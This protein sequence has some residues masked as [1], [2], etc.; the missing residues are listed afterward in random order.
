MEQRELDVALDKLLL[1]PNNYRFQADPRFQQVRES[2]Y[3]EE[4]VQRRTAERISSEGL[5]ELKASILHNGFLTF[6]KI[7]VRPWSGSEEHFVVVEGNRRLA[8][9]RALIDEHESGTDLRQDVLALQAG[10][11]VIVVETDD[12]SH[13]LALMGIRHVGGVRQW[14]SYQSS[15]LVAELRDRHELEFVDI[16]PRLGMSVRET[17]RRYRAFKALRQME[18]DEEFGEYAERRMYP[19]F[20]EAVSQPRLR[21][22]LGWDDTAFEF[23][24]EAHRREFYELLS[25]H[26]Q[27]D[28]EVLPPKIST[29]GEV[30]EL[31]VVLDSEEAMSVLRE[32][33]SSFA[34]ALGTAKAELL[35]STWAKEVAEARR[36]LAA[37]PAL[38]LAS[39]SPEN[40]DLLEAVRDLAG[41]LLEQ[42]RRLTD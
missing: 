21:E 10:V 6:E 27:E 26:A 18:E 37:V 42:H 32:A 33:A 4:S 15:K 11:P 39:M 1:D 25:P 14:G 30:R 3:A 17:T 9:L 41:M 13:Y 12:E 40:L 8:A 16:G 31:K 23:R 35:Q 34:D 38:E 7:I 36:A 5:A 29:A 28:D 19:L 22:W 24:D 2:R 20:H